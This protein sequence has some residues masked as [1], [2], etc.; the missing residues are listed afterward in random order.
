ML[1]AISLPARYGGGARDAI[2]GFG[3]GEVEERSGNK[4]SASSA[5]VRSL[6]TG[7][8][9]SAARQGL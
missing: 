5:C 4:P 9:S 8:I 7:S 3:V 6:G 2:G 1:G